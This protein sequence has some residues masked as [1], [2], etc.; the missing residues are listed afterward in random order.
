MP[1][2][3][4]DITDCQS[5]GGA[6]GGD[7]AERAVGPQLHDGTSGVRE[8]RG[9]EGGR[10]V[11][12]GLATGAEADRAR[13][14]TETVDILLQLERVALDDELRLL[15]LVLRK[16]V[17]PFL[18]GAALSVRPRRIAPKH[19]M[20]GPAGSAALRAATR[21]A[22]TM[23]A[24]PLGSW[25]DSPGKCSQG[26]GRGGLQLTRA[27]LLQNEVEIRLFPQNVAKRRVAS[28]S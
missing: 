15:E 24:E 17:P 12:V 13:G 14:D 19:E 1:N 6:G 3:S 21:I 28:I 25:Q 9:H 18:L 26:L 7:C 2:I 20:G 10:S 16:G 27:K 22:P 8:R 11:G 5:S 23:H 4:P